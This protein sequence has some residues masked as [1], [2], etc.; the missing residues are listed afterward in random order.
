MHDD[1]AGLGQNGAP[2]LGAAKRVTTS[3]LFGIF[4]E[5]Q[6][7]AQ[8]I[9]TR[10]LISPLMNKDFSVRH[11]LPARGNFASMNLNHQKC[12]RV[13]ILYTSAE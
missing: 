6:V 11:P 5:Y 10:V 8:L 9:A 13:H 2:V 4:G 7:M 3:W 1:Q 12:R